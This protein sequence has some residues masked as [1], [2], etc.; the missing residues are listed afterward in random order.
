MDQVVL[1]MYSLSTM[2][3][4]IPIPIYLAA[5]KK[6]IPIIPVFLVR[7]YSNRNITTIFLSQFPAAE[8]SV[9]LPGSNLLNKILLFN[10][11]IYIYI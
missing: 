1:H 2:G 5:V 11:R 10:I 6:T 4:M 3:M 9:L 7:F 8:V